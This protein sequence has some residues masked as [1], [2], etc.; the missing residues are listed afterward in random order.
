MKR[1]LALLVNDDGIRSIGILALKEELNNDF[2]CVVV[3]PSKERSGI[4]KA[5]TVG[6]VVKVEKV[7]L[8]GSVAYSVDGTPADAVLIAI[9]KILRRRPDVV[10]A[11]INLGPNL[12]IDDILNSGTVGAAME[13]AIHDIPSIAASYCIAREFNDDVASQMLLKDPGLRLTTKIVRA[14]VNIVVNDGLPEGVDLLSVNVPD[15]RFGIKG[16]RVT[17]PSKKGYPDIHV[18]CCGGYRIARWDLTLY[19]RDS[20]DTDVEAV[21]SGYISITPLSLNFTSQLQDVDR[22]KRA[23][24]ALRS[25][26]EQWNATKGL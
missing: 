18:E 6:D 8:H 1:P 22:L 13:A 3:G 17:R 23:I 26:V 20:E 14:L 11:G 15:H 12:G 9:N 4:G 16:V 25:I 21:R 19:P 5:L 2:E 10:V 7:T 24:E